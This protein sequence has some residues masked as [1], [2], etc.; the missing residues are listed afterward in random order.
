MREGWLGS[1]QQAAPATGGERCYVAAVV[2]EVSRQLIALGPGERSLRGGKPFF[3]V[4]RGAVSSGCLLPLLL[5]RAG[6]GS[7]ARDG[8]GGELKLRGRGEGEWGTGMGS[9]H[10]GERR[11]ILML[12]RLLASDRDGWGPGRA[13]NSRREQGAAAQGASRAGRASQPS[14]T[15]PP[16]LLAYLP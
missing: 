16:L 11:R 9:Q 2:C 8:S 5:D 4:S 7:A 6:E 13:K 12:A 14:A 3:Q 15:K 10:H 1:A